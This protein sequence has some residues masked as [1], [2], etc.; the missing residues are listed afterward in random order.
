MDAE[1]QQEEKISKKRHKSHI[2]YGRRN[3]RG[4][5]AFQEQAQES[6]TQL[7]LHSGVPQIY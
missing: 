5:K 4:E 2:E 3:S 1:T 7:F 6:E